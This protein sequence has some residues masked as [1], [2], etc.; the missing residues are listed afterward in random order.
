MNFAELLQQ[1]AARLAVLLA[2]LDAAPFCDQ[3]ICFRWREL[4]CSRF[5][6]LVLVR[7]CVRES[8]SMGVSSIGRPLLSSRKNVRVG[9]GSHG[10]FA[11][12]HMEYLEITSG[13][14]TSNLCS[15]NR[16]CSQPAV[17]DCMY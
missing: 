9:K 6:Q 1:L 5:L 12:I 11:Q 3:R 10:K 13:Y 16:L 8:V 2:P 17:V 4:G 15:D 14:V 7:A